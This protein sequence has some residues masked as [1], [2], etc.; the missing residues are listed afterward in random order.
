MVAVEIS[1]GYGVWEPASGV[2]NG[3]LERAVALPQEKSDARRNYNTR[4]IEVGFIEINERSCA[5]RRPD[6]SCY[7]VKDA[8]AI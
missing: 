8:V 6:A 2:Q 3:I 5:F 7:K 1:D 4:K